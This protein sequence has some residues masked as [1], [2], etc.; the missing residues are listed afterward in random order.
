MPDV[1]CPGYSVRFDC[2]LVYAAQLHRCQRRKG[3]DIPYITHLLAVASL[4]GE[5]GGSEDAVIAGLL[6]DAVEDQGGRPVLETIRGLFGERVA[7][8][9]SACSDTDQSPKPPWLERKRAYLA[10][11]SDLD[12][13]ALLVSAADKLHNV[14]AILSDYRVFG[15]GL[16]VRFNAGRDEQL[17]YYAELE[18]AFQRRFDRLAALDDTGWGRQVQPLMDAL[19]RVTGDLLAA[20]GG[21]PAESSAHAT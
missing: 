20:A 19:K 15:D 14:R 10:H 3:S 4:V 5:H 18:A 17:W 11:M 9:V 1:D 13:D 2:A 16:W 6:H 8:I 12:G 7:G 21:T